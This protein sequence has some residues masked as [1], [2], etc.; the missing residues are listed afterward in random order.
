MLATYGR[1]WIEGYS[2]QVWIGPY[3]EIIEYTMHVIESQV[4]SSLIAG[5]PIQNSCGCNYE[6]DHM[7][8]CKIVATAVFGPERPVEAGTY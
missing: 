2:N 4:A 5:D 1:R 7:Q 8:R 6:Q 3:V